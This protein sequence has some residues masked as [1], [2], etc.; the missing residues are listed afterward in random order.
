MNG[1]I[2][3]GV[4]GSVA[5]QRALRWALEEAK[6]RHVEVDVVNAYRYEMY[7]SEAFGMTAL[8]PEADLANDS[9]ALVREAVERAADVAKDHVVVR[10]RSVEGPAANVLLDASASADLLVVGSRGR[11]GFAGLLLGSVSQQCANHA[12]CPVVIVPHGR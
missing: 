6:L 7:W 2:V 11:G 9:E 8:A 4:D 12:R 5:A 10:A 3:V 1:R